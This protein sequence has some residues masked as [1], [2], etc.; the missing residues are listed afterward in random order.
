MLL[1][2]SNL[3]N[4]NTIFRVA[5]YKTKFIF[6]SRP[7]SSPEVNKMH[8]E[9]G[10]TLVIFPSVIIFFFL[11]IYNSFS[12]LLCSM[13]F[14]LLI[15]PQCKRQNGKKSAHILLLLKTPSELFISVRIKLKASQISAHYPWGHLLYHSFM[16]TLFQVTSFLADHQNN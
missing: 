2:L 8:P 15:F 1:C 11:D 6:L 9:S 16:F 5:Q 12:C 10:Y 3:I 7:I 14:F 13:A 4:V